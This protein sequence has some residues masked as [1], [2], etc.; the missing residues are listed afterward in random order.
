MLD[1]RKAPPASPQLKPL[2]WMG[3]L[4]HGPIRAGRVTFTRPE[5]WLPA[6]G[7]ISAPEEAAR[8]V[9]PAYLGV[10]GPASMKAFDA[11]L[12]R[13]RSSKTQLRGWFESVSHRLATVDVD[14][15]ECHARA[16][17]R[18]AAGHPAHAG[19]AHAGGIRPVPAGTGN[20]RPEHRA[21][22]AARA[23]ERDRRL[24]LTRR[25]SVGRH[26]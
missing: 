18:R 12:T 13:G 8:R 1:L 20:R 25:P 9:I 5:T 23:G 15:R 21:R 3:H 10:Y 22:A 14:G 26:H 7:G 16:E 19:R 24:N 4:C 11:W 6:W 2:A 17:D